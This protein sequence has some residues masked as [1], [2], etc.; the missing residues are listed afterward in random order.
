MFFFS[1]TLWTKIKLCHSHIYSFLSKS[2]KFTTLLSTNPWTFHFKTDS[3]HKR[4]YITFLQNFPHIF[5]KPALFLFLEVIRSKPR[6]CEAFY[7][8][9]MSGCHPHGCSTCYK[10]RKAA[11]WLER[12]PVGL[13]CS[14]AQNNHRAG[15]TC[16][17]QLFP[18]L[19]EPQT[20][21]HAHTLMF[22]QGRPESLRISIR[23]RG[24]CRKVKA[25]NCVISYCAPQCHED[26][27]RTVHWQ[28]INNIY[29][30]GVRPILIRF[31][32]RK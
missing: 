7:W 4:S 24:S 9:I 13:V 17:R 10:M 2:E 19:L 5:H 12:L 15:A 11:Y 29:G 25:D 14:L 6:V 31:A 16:P 8:I 1:I 18:V 21:T 27:W 30:A 23:C 26:W 32:C 22:S 20:Y 28:N 3:K